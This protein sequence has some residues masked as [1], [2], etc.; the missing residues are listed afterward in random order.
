MLKRVLR[1]PF[2]FKGRISIP[3][4]IKFPFTQDPK[5]SDTVMNK[6]KQDA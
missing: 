4:I 1:L 5:Y 2:L 6:L 3:M